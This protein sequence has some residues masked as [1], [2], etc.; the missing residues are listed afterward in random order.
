[1]YVASE[2]KRNAASVKGPLRP[3]PCF[4]SQFILDLPLRRLRV[5]GDG[6]LPS[7][8]MIPFP[9]AVIGVVIP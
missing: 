3:F 6:I 5:E 7:L 1:M 4:N 8:H 9:W 2:A